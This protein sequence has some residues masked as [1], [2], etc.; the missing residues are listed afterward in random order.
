[1]ALKT[2]THNSTHNFY[3][4]VV[5]IPT[6]VRN[7]PL[8]RPRFIAIFLRVQIERR[9]NLAVTQKS[10]HGFRFDFRRCTS[11]FAELQEERH[12]GTPAGLYPRYSS[13]P[14]YRRAVRCTWYE[15]Y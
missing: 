7:S 5:F 15:T 4:T 3:C 12:K 11:L 1:L 13:H 2:P 9:L 6:A 10:L 14:S 8:R